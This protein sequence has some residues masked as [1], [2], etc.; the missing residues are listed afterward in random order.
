GPRLRR[1]PP[2]ALGDP[3]ATAE[4]APTPAGAAFP[5]ARPPAG[6]PRSVEDGAR[7]SVGLALLLRWRPGGRIEARS[8]RARRRHR[9]RDL[10]LRLRCLRPR[11]EWRRSLR[12]LACDALPDRSLER[13]ATL[14][15]ADALLGAAMARRR[16]R[17]PS[18]R[19]GNR[20]R[21]RP[22]RRRLRGAASLGPPAALRGRRR[23]PAPRR[24][25]ASPC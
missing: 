18:D 1:S 12:R 23:D 14:A 11:G 5:R 6:L 17:G 24:E 7:P 19:G 25:G 16:R 13:R 2:H 10:P 20:L 15:T 22:R 4:K 8:A 9:P 21:L 3:R